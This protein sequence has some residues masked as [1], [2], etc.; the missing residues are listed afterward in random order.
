GSNRPNS[1]PFSGAGSIGPAAAT[2]GIAAGAGGCKTGGWP[3]PTTATVQQ[4]TRPIERSSGRI[5]EP[6]C[7]PTNGAPAMLNKP[8]ADKQCDLW[9]AVDG[10]A[11]V[12]QA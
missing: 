2:G 8:A 4:T 5:A 6:P 1:G 9:R 12:A 3:E 7:P 10:R 11:K